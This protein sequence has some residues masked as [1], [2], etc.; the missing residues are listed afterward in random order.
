[1]ARIDQ[2]SFVDSLSAGDYITA[3]VSNYNDPRRTTISVL[4]EYMQGNLTFTEVGF[5]NQY[6]APSATGFDVAVTD[7][8]DDIWLIIT[9]AT[10]YA[11]GAITLPSVTNAV[12]G[13]EILVICTQAVTTF[14]VNANGANDV[15]GE[16]ATLA[17][18]DYFRLKYDSNSANWYRIG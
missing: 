16:P 9:P 14:V 6:S 12:N 15:I 10:G 17:A 1:M 8:G 5:T 2:L 13:Q 7:G 18:N 11:D 3:F 4:A